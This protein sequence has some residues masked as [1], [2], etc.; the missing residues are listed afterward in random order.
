MDSHR[1]SRRNSGQQSEST[2]TKQPEVTTFL[3]KESQ[4][5]TQSKVSPVRSWSWEIISL[6]FALALL[7]A[8]IAVPAHYN[9][10]VLK[11]WPYDI[12]LNT[13]IAILS[14][15]MRASMM[16]VVAELV[17]QMG[18]HSL[19]KPRPVSDLHHFDNASRGIL[20][21]I[22][23]FWNV[24]P[25]LA[26]IIAAVIIILSPAIAPFSQQ[27]VRTVPC[28]RE[29]SGSASLPVS[30]YVPAQGSSYRL[31]AGQ[32]EISNDMKATMINGLVNPTGK[33]TAIEATCASGNC[34]FTE[35][36]Q[37]V[38]HTSIAMC[39]SCL[40]TTEF[41]KLNVTKKPGYSILN[42]TLPNT[43]WLQPIGGG[44]LIDA[45]TGDV[46]WA[47]G[48]VDSAFAEMTKRSITN[49]TILTSS[50]SACTNISGAGANC[51]EDRFTSDTPELY[52][53]QN[54]VAI[55]C[56]LY[57]CLKHYHAQVKEAKLEEKVIIEEPLT[58]IEIIYSENGQPKVKNLK[59]TTIQSPCLVDGEEYNFDNFSRMAESTKNTSTVEIG[60]KNYTAPNQCIYE[61]RVTYLMGLENFMRD[62]IFNGACEFSSTTGTPPNCGNRWWLAPLYNSSYEA[63]DTA[64]DQLATV[65]TN[66]FRRQAAINMNISG[67]DKVTGTVNETTICTVFDWRWVLL[68]AGLMV[69]TMVLLIHVVVQSYTNA[70]L[71]I[72]K[73]S[74]L[75]LFFYGPNVLNDLTRQTD[76]DELQRQAGKTKVEFKDDDGIRLRRIDTTA[77]ES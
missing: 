59:R 20:G 1:S 43:Q 45:A 55:T 51:P 47:L 37:G 61:G 62:T 19:R 44:Q 34:T 12:S 64:V 40:D 65:I 16:L 5:T 25:R 36:S 42:Y 14:T 23:L 38:T 76:L 35:N 13:I 71:P 28:P 63:L 33:D 77:T 9:D 56:A 66:N 4:T 57:P 72:W 69:V 31:S 75:P 3:T 50:Q 6:L 22:K 7:V 10:K 49:L 73:T 18:W 15:F 8:I 54:V 60:G 67:S 11:R 68:P 46:D 39:S 48:G 26:S 2:G 17:G 53:S 32:S 70:A 24:P 74:V 30:H 21:A 58:P 41:I 29:V 52:R 27:A